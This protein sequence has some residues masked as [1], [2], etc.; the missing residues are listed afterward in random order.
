MINMDAA[1]LRQALTNAQH[2]GEKFGGGVAWEGQADGL[3]EEE[4]PDRFQ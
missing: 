2:Q 3:E 1:S 4:G